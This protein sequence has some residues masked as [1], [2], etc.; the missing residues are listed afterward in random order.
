VSGRV[1]YAGISNYSGWQ[2]AAAVA[3]QRAWPGRTRLA[4]TQVEYSLLARSIEAEVLPAA[5]YGGL[6]VLAWSPL[7]RGVLTGKYRDAVPP[8]SRATTT[9]AGFVREYFTDR[10]A[11]ITSAV[12]TAAR[13]LGV[14]PGA[15]ALTWVRDRPGITAPV[16]GA[17]TAGQLAESL[18]AEQLV[19]PSDVRVTLDDVSAPT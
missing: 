10:C 1:R 3:W 14:T 12:V 7:G 5:A 11:R 4:S 8:G 9:R 18:A 16:V 2:T 6:G 17:R 19:L 13:D 15:V